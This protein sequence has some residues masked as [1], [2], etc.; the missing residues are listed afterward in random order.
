[1]IFGHFALAAGIRGRWPRSSLLW[2]LPA[3]IAPD[4]LDVLMAAAGICNPFGLYSH[5]IPAVAVL[6]A[7]VGGAAYLTTAGREPGSTALS[8]AI[9]S[10]VVVLLHPALDFLTGYKLLW[11]GGALVGLRLYERPFTDF[12]IE[13]AMVI[14]GWL[15]LRRSTPAP[16]WAVAPAALCTALVLQGAANLVKDNLKPTACELESAPAL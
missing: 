2:L 16:R 12:A 13:S 10:A 9:A 15:I 11:P 5:T 6:A 3:S 14:V 8:T 4:L 1:V 7:A